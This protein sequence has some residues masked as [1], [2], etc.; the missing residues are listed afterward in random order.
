MLLLILFFIVFC[1]VLSFITCE[2]MNT[3]TVPLKEDP[4]A[5]NKS[6]PILGTATSEGSTIK[7]DTRPTIKA[8]DTFL[9]VLGSLS[10][11]S[12]RRANTLPVKHIRAISIKNMYSGN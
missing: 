1:S 6:V 10:I 11:T 2:N 5:V 4:K 8:K 7:A 9:K 3:N 12:V